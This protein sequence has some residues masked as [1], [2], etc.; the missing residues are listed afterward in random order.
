MYKQ[1]FDVSSKVHD[2]LNFI[3]HLVY[4]YERSQYSR[5]LIYVLLYIRTFDL[6]TIC[7]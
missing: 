4:L 5:T 6:R 3:V 2:N 1:S 7:F